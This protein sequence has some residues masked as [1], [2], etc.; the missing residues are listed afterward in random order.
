M[1]NMFSRRTTRG[2][3]GEIK[4]WVTKH[5]NLTDEDLVTVAELRCVET[6]CPPIETVVTVHGADGV[7]RSWHIHQTLS[8][9]DEA[10]VVASIS[11]T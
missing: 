2:R 11:E 6:G 8:Q 10:L 1:S 3:A 4:G 9:I 7:R 5:L